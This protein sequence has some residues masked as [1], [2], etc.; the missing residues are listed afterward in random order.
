MNRII[1]LFILFIATGLQAQE[2]SASPYSYYGIGDV[3]PN[4]TAEARAMGGFSAIPDSIHVNLQNPAFLTQLKWT[5]Y[6]IGMTYNT[7]N[8]QTDSAS[9]KARRSTLDYLSYA[10]PANKW[11]FS[12]LIMPYSSVGYKVQNISSD[13]TMLTQYTAKGGLNKATASAAYQIHPRWSVGVQVGVLFG[14]IES[15]SYLYQSGIQYN[16][17][18]QN[19]SYLSGFTSTLGLSY[20]LKRTNKPTFTASVTFTPQVGLQTSNQR[21]LGSSDLIAVSVPNNT[22]KIPTLTT[23]GLGYGAEKHWFVGT[24][25]AFQGQNQL[26]QRYDNPADARFTSGFK[27]SAGGYFIPN[28]NSFD[29]YYKRMVYR[30]GVRWSQSGLVLRDTPIQETA[31][32]AGLG[33]PIGGLLSNVNFTLEM[34]QLG[35][36][37]KGLIQENYINFSLGFSFNDR[38]FIKRKY[39]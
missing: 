3:K 35:T 24:E 22:L 39:D 17:R 23:V 12:L 10:F 9:E 36:T 26:T 15:N 8:L 16:T 25:F 14:K 5:N 31:V 19:L 21:V 28:Y 27:W 29:H 18:E 2:G 6:A 34:G 20:C 33:F 30:A 4:A 37:Q 11:A 7:L 13:N 38:W 1:A 32:T